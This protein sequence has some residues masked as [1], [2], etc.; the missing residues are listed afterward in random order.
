MTASK[1]RTR[2]FRK[3]RSSH[4]SRTHTTRLKCWGKRGKTR[5]KHKNT[6]TQPPPPKKQKGRFL[7]RYLSPLPVSFTAVFFLQPYSSRHVQRNTCL[8]RF[9]KKLMRPY[10]LVYT[11]YGISRTYP[12]PSPP[13]L[14]SYCNSSVFLPLVPR[15]PPKQTC[16]DVYY[17]QGITCQSLQHPRKETSSYVQRAA[18]TSRRHPTES[19]RTLRQ[20]QHNPITDIAS[21]KPVHTPLTTTALAEDAPVGEFRPF[22]GP[23]HI[24]QKTP[25][26][27]VMSIVLEESAAV[28]VPE[29]CGR[30]V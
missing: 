17:R 14:V 22:L 8:A 13:P 6:D 26:T 9:K 19:T 21:L 12:R 4:I 15:S 2:K 23:L 25:Q 18:K 30:V 10:T 27:R 29:C 1:R 20:Q 7:L 28:R 11:V 24:H 3:E 16:T 5:G